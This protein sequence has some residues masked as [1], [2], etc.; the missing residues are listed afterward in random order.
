[1]PPFTNSC[2]L[3]KQNQKKEPFDWQ[4]R[5]T[6]KIKI[7]KKLWQKIAIFSV[8][9]FF[10]LSNQQVPM[11]FFGLDT[12]VSKDTK[13]EEYDFSETYDDLATKLV[14][15]ND[16][17]ND[18]TFGDFSVAKDFD[19]AGQTARVAD[20]LDE[21]QY[22]FARSHKVPPPTSYGNQIPSGPGGATG[23]NPI[24]RNFQ[25]IPSLWGSSDQQQQ[26]QQQQPQP[27]QQQQ[28]QQDQ[29]PKMLSLEEIEAQMMAKNQSPMYNQFGYPQQQQQFPGNYPPPNQFTIPPQGFPQDPALIS[30]GPMHQQFPPNQQFMNQFPPHFQQLPG[31]NQNILF[32]QQQQPQQPQDQQQSQSQDAPYKLANERANP[33]PSL[34]EVIHE[35]LAQNNADN[36]RLL[37]KSRKIAQIVKYNNLMSSWDKNF[38]T[39][40]QLQQM[41]TDDP[42][43]E[44]FY[45]QVHTAIQARNNPQQ[46]LN[47]FARTYLFQRGQRNGMFRK[48]DNPLQRMQQQV[49]QAIAN[50]KEHPKKEQITLEGALGKIS[51][52]SGKR[53]RQTLTLKKLE[54]DS[55]ESGTTVRAYDLRSLLKLIETIY[56]TLLEIESLERS[57][58]Q[59]PAEGQSDEGAFDEWQTKLTTQVDKLWDELQ[60]VTNNDPD[61]NEVHPFIAIL[62]HDKGKKLIPRIFR[63]ISQK[64]HLTILTRVIAHIDTLDV[65]K[66]GAYVDGQDLKPRTKESIELFSQTVLPPL[67]HLISESPFDVVIGLLDILINSNNAVLVGS[68]KVG[69]AFLTVLISR[70]ELISQQDEVSQEELE[71]WQ[72]TFNNLFVKLQGHLSGIFPPRNVDDS[73]VW[74]FLASL[75]LAAKLEHQR[76]IVDEVRERIFGTMA[77][78]KALPYELGLQKISNLNLFLNVMGLNATTTEIG[79]LNP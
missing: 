57:R 39:R 68:T 5:T 55:K 35:D 14:E 79:E 47:S 64:Q 22:V 21:E 6:T 4:Q 56:A 51:L 15:D 66:G 52:G 78:A 17:L 19:F 20:T 75:A 69:L 48:Y 28:P 37:K 11:S 54:G 33:V 29:K 63:H 58:P 34:T 24:S 49:Q 41:I 62:S 42:Y 44:D 73:Y 45:Y 40:I 60:V 70:A 71:N 3:C 67:V 31:Q 53:P 27:Q 12:V 13:P 9:F 65:V 10:S 25:P 26:Q 43:N 76:V 59:P 36:D 38:I 72:N 32:Q 46:P 77:E 2:K 16:D 1:M 8:F 7:K 61:S 23:S 18:E 30:A 74:H 50:A